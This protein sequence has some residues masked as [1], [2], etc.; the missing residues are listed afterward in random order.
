VRFQYYFYAL[1]KK[2]RQ[3]GCNEFLARLL[4]S[5]NLSLALLFNFNSMF[6]ISEVVIDSNWLTKIGDKIYH[7]KELAIVFLTISLIVY[8]IFGRKTKFSILESNLS[9]VDL[10]E[11]Y[12]LKKYHNYF[13][14]TCIMFFLSIM[15][16]FIVNV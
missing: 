13:I 1:Y 15:L 12:G 7:T 10:G 9:S 6:L 3:N 5:L 11:D 16:T 2:D 14:G 4:A 8:L